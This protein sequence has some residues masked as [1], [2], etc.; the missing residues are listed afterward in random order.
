ML[1]DLRHLLRNLRRS[2]ASAAA[3]V[4]TLSLTLGAGTAIFAV[5]DAVLLTPPPFTDPDALV[6]L[7][8]VLP[9]DPASARRAVRYATLEAWRERA[10]SLAVMEGAD[11]THLT[12]TELGA[13]DRVHVTGVTPGFLPLLGVAPALGRMFEANDLSQP[14]VILTDAFWRAKLAADP[15]AIGRQIVLGGRPHTIVGVLPKGFAFAL[16][17]S[18]VWRPLQLPPPNP[19][20]PAA[21]A[22]F[23]VLVVARLAS[24]VTPKEL[25]AMLDEVSRRSSPPAQVVATRIA[26]AIAG[27]STRTLGLLAGAA[28]LAFL[29]AFANLAGLLLV[30]SIDRRRELAVRTALG[31]RRS[32]IARQLVLEAAALVAVGILGGVLLALWLT[33]A[34]GRVALEQFGAVA[35]REVAVSWRVIAVVAMVAAACAGVSGLLPAFVA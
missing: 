32:E 17:R 8:E 3:A 30:R 31:A 20:D 26:T 13:A 7:G 6:T 16:D 18:D 23:R 29:I 21:R 35:N 22:G 24:N 19:E 1:I 27:G 33:P 14:V 9:G 12:L 11:G 34:V 28:A 10:G 5:V 15:A 4:L 2:P 25:A